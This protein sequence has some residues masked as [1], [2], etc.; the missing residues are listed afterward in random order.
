LRKG[1]ETDLLR[2]HIRHPHRPPSEERLRSTRLAEFWAAASVGLLLVIFFIL[3]TVGRRY[4]M[5]GLVTMIALVTFIE[6]TFRGQLTR[7][8]TSVTISTAIVAAL[9][10]VYRYFW[11]IVEVGVLVTGIY[12]L[13]ENLRE[14]RR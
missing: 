13:W 8:I 12:I 1:S 9:V 3:I 6:A 14:L 10:L 7:F 2:D 11:Q 4:L 5:I